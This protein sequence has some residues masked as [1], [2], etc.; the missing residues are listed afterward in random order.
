MSLF[1][2]F[3]VGALVGLAG[4]GSSEQAFEASDAGPEVSVE[5]AGTD[6]TGCEV[7]YQRA[8]PF[9][10]KTQEGI[11][12]HE[13][14]FGEDPTPRHVHIGW[15]DR[16]SSTSISFAWLTDG[17]GSAERTLASAVQYA[18]GE[19]TDPEALTSLHRGVSFGFG[20]SDNDTFQAHD[21][22]MCGKLKPDTVY[23]YRVGGEGHWSPIHTFRTPPTPGT[24]DTFTVGF[25]GD[26]RG[27]YEL[28]GSILQQM[29]SFDPD[30]YVF[31]G[32]MVDIGGQQW[33]WE[34]WFG[35]AGD[36]LARK[37]LL[38]AHGNH[39]FLAVNYFAQFSLP[40][41]EEWFHVDYGNLSMV[42]LND[43]VSHRGALQDEQPAFIAQTLGASAADWKMAFHHRSMFSICTRHNSALDVRDAWFKPLMAAGTQLVFAGHNHIYERSQPIAAGADGEYVPVEQLGDGAVFVVTGGA[44]APLY[45]SFND[46]LDFANQ[47]QTTEHFMIGEF[48]PT[49]ATFTSYDLDL[50][51]IDQF[52]VPRP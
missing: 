13:Q 42:A 40:G 22:R 36:V 12:P 2:A 32:D 47:V 20:G 44:G 14:V 33:E 15:P 7:G 5:L 41:N 1:R 43:T 6:P 19:H 10:E 21:V 29:E 16:D 3:G 45:R 50:N 35:A 28:W 25:A 46:E 4:C 26:S 49:A 27:A 24:F 37:V 18:E 30:F 17:E 31:P 48:G 34:A 52:T 38:P 11:S 23:S 51:V 9:S 39:E 8:L